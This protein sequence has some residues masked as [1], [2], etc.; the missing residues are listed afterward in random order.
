M[1]R[2]KPP[3]VPVARHPSNRS[4]GTSYHGVEFDLSR[5]SRDHREPEAVC[6]ILLSSE[7][8]RLRCHSRSATSI[9]PTCVVHAPSGSRHAASGP[10]LLDHRTSAV[11][12]RIAPSTRQTMPTIIKVWYAVAVRTCELPFSPSSLLSDGL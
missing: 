10:L 5:A 12:S 6:L 1:P 11:R 9:P 4:A 2:L 3:K 7:E 8:K